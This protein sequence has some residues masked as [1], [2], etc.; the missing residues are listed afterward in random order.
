MLLEKVINQANK[1]EINIS[2]EIYERITRY[3]NSIYEVEDISSNIAELGMESEMNIGIKSIVLN[4]LSKVKGVLKT[5]EET[6]Q[7]IRQRIE[8]R[9]SELVNQIIDVVTHISKQ[10][11]GKSIPVIIY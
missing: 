6:K 11:K 1:N 7:I 4:L 10:L 5:S 2:K 3:W 9:S 8:S